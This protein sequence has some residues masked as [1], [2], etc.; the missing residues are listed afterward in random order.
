MYKATSY[1]EP[2][3]NYQ[4]HFLI[5]EVSRVLESDSSLN[6]HAVLSYVRDENSIQSVFDSVTYAKVFSILKF[7]NVLTLIVFFTGSFHYSNVGKCAGGRKVPNRCR[8]LFE[9]IFLSKHFNQRFVARNGT[10]RR[11]FKKC[12][13]CIFKQFFSK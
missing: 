6:T 7:M 5:K 3:W 9:Q 4:E 1:V 10:S 13:F 8:Q 11:M 2:T 12:S